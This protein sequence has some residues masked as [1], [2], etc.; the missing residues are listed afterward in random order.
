M[1]RLPVGTP[2]RPTYRLATARRRCGLTRCVACGC[3]SRR[4][5]TSARPR[6]ACAG[7]CGPVTVRAGPT[8]RGVALV[9]QRLECV[10]N[11]TCGPASQPTSDLGRGVVRIGVLTQEGGNLPPQLACSQPGGRCRCHALDGR[12]S[13]PQK[14][15][16]AA[17]S[18]RCPYDLERCD[19]QRYLS[20]FSD[21]CHHC[22]ST[23]PGRAEAAAGDRAIAEPRIGWRVP[24]QVHEG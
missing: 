9:H 7:V 6:R 11:R 4:C 5:R 3:R 15:S 21:S 16:D 19:L 8:V 20:L 13:R 2:N 24:L 22:G 17:R 1:V 12:S 18:S 10:A 14:S 23:C